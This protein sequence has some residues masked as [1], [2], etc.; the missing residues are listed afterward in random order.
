VFP[1]QASPQAVEVDLVAMVVMAICS[2]LAL[3]VCLALVGFCLR[4]RAGR[5]VDRSDPPENKPVLEVVWILVPILL[6]VGMFVLGA[7]SYYDLYVPPAD[8]MEI[9]VV[10]EQW[11]WT[12]RHPGG[13]REINTLHVPL[14]RKVRLKMISQDVIHSFAL[15]EFRTKHDVLP[16]R[17]S[18]LWIE[19]T[20]LGSF[21]LECSEYCGTEHAEMR[22]TVV[23]MRPQEYSAWAATDRTGS[24]ENRGRLLYR[25][26]ACAGCH[27]YQAGKSL[28]AAPLL[29]GIV[30]KTVGL[31]GGGSTLVDEEYLRRSIL[32][33]RA[34]VVAGFEP[35]MPTYEGQISEGDLLDLIAFLRSRTTASPDLIEPEEGRP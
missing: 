12:V 10:G 16:G 11:L 24:P 25:R 28:T 6:G 35:L 8:A 15:P 4:Y 9:E 17:Y 5:V 26:L 18:Y 7:R 19:P 20:R 22:G 31:E 34:Q 13:R 32:R 3:G 2:A 29:D 23:V 14:G 21:T 1:Q 33:P 30:G 27:E